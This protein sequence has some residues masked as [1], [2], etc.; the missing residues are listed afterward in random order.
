MN[1][2]RQDP[3]QEAATAEADH[4]LNELEKRSQGATVLPK[5]LLVIDDDPTML[6]LVNL[7]F[8][9]D[10]GQVLSSQD[11]REGLRLALT[12]KPDLILLDHDMPEMKGIEV[13]K[14]LKQMPPT[15]QIPVIMLTGNNQEAT[16]L[17][18]LGCQVSG[19]LL[20]PCA[21]EALFQAVMNI[22]PKQ[23]P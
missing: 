18:A 7:V 22:L 3:T 9:Q 1:M 12:Y 5:T 10:F 20:K 2:E 6:R 17:A 16:V 19:Y 15:Q 13:L 14:Q 4:H 11:P 8:R 21:P 23:V